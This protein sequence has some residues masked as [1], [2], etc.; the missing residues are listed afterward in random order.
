MVVKIGKE[1]FKDDFKKGDYLKRL[2]QKGTT[3]DLTKYKVKK[4][5][6]DI[7]KK[8]VGGSA[9]SQTDD[10]TL[11]PKADLDGDGTFSKYE[12]K[13]G[14]A[15]QNAMA[16]NKKPEGAFIGKLFTQD[17]IKEMFSRIKGDP[18]IQDPEA[19]RKAY[20]KYATAYGNEPMK[21]DP[22]VAKAGTGKFMVKGM[23]AA[24]RGGL[25]KGSS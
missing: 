3:K 20:N 9:K 22:K 19:Y 2:K 21:D 12:R 17:K 18:S 16:K 25:T 6:V 8:A 10:M 15:I 4:I 24:I 11:S 23:G 14:M 1:I 7:D 5:K 13:R